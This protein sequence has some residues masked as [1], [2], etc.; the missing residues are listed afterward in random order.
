MKELF[1]KEMESLESYVPGRPIED[2]MREFGLTRVV[3]LA[4]NENPLGPS[5]KAVQAIR[6]EAESVNIYPDPGM[7][8]LRA[9][10]GKKHDV[11]P[12]QVLCTNGGETAI[13]MVS[14]A[15]LEEG[16]E[17]V[18]GDPSFSLYDIGAQLM[19]ATIRR[20]PLSKETLGYDLEGMLD[21]V[22]EKTKIFYLC[23]PNNPTG[24]LVT[25]DQL[26]IV[27]DR[28]PEDVVLFLDEAYFEFAIVHPEYP[29]GMEVLKKRP[30]TIVLRTLSK[31]SGIAGLRVGYVVSDEDL[32]REV[33]KA[34]TVFSVNRIAQ[35]AALAA[36]ADEEHIEKSVALT[37]ASLARMMEYFDEKGYPYIKAAGNFIFVDV[38]TDTR[39]VYIDLQREG[40]IVRPGFLWKWDTWLRISSGTME[41]TELLIEAMENVL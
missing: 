31:V 38:G 40:V 25:K 26:Q 32:I 3:K 19:G 33:S 30:R 10:I 2:V 23:N 14:I 41:E 21:A 20:I 6:D 8:D 18:V 5:P 15:M 27:L 1:R 9:A 29:D 4:S 28:L 39:K 13:Q 22:N 37:R 34:S 36:L 7:V 11:S 12:E 16:D 17:I 35:K 24:T